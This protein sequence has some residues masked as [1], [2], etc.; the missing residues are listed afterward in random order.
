MVN[1]L[2]QMANAIDAVTAIDEAQT[3]IT[4]IEFKILGIAHVMAYGVT[5]EL[6]FARQVFDCNN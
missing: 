3:T 6:G 4:T 2:V 1:S 5:N